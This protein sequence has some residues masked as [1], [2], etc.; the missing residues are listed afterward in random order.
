MSDAVSIRSHGS[1]TMPG[2][3][4]A[5]FSPALPLYLTGIGLVYLAV[6]T[7]WRQRAHQ[8][9]T[10]DNQRCLSTSIKSIIAPC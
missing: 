5:V 2:G 1:T 3:G 9:T 8:R 6:Q 7:R 4:T 10:R